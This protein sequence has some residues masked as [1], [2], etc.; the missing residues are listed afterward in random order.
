MHYQRYMEVCR[1]I[2][3]RTNKIH[4][5]WILFS[6]DLGEIFFYSKTYYIIEIVHKFLLKKKGSKESWALMDLLL[7]ESKRGLT[8]Q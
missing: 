2:S 6:E 3:Y 4:F 8:N 1:G 5:S 7:S